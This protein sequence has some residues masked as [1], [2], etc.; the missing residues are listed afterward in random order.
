M[1]RSLKQGAAL[2]NNGKQRTYEPEAPPGLKK[3]LRYAIKTQKREMICKKF[4]NRIECD[5]VF[6]ELKYGYIDILT[7]IKNHEA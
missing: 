2:R 1:R 5:R 6:R 7:S 4:Y 3:S